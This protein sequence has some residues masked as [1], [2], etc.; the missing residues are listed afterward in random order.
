MNQIASQAAARHRFRV[1]EHIVELIGWLRPVVER[2]AKH[3]RSL[4]DQIR[5]AA[6][7]AGAL[8]R[9]GS[10][11]RGGNRVA[12]IHQAMS[13]ADEVRA[14]PAHRGGVGLRAGRG[15]RVGPARSRGGDAVED[16]AL[17]R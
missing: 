13:E 10:Y 17:T 9:E 11:A 14:H 4:A 7:A 16:H 15:A 6:S 5:R 8:C 3:D 12:K 1:F 2:I